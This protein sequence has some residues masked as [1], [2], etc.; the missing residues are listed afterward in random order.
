MPFRSMVPQSVPVSIKQHGQKKKNGAK[1][2]PCQEEAERP[3]AAEAG[4]P[5]LKNGSPFEDSFEDCIEHESGVCEDV[6]DNPSG[7][8]PPSVSVP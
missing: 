6:L 1:P 8:P 2:A 3:S 4:V 7:K 5:G